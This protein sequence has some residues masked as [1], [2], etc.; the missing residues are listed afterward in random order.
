MGGRCSSVVGMRRVGGEGVGRVRSVRDF[1]L[2][3][4]GRVLESIDSLPMLQHLW[5]ECVG[6][7]GLLNSDDVAMSGVGTFFT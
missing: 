3:L 7:G 5:T 2:S 4:G 6:E 1:V